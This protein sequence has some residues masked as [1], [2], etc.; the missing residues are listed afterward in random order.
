MLKQI[1][2]LFLFSSSPAVAQVQDYFPFVS[3]S[4]W[5]DRSRFEGA[6]LT[7]RQDAERGLVSWD[8]SSRSEVPFLPFD[9]EAFASIQ[10]DGK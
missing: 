1:I 6:T 9:G 7:L 2:F 3:G 4:T 8:D 5:L 10:P